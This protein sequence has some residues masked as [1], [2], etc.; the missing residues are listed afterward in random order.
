MA[1]ALLVLIWVVA[2]TMLTWQEFIQVAPAV[3]PLMLLVLWRR[4]SRAAL[5][6]KLASELVS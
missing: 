6:A 4:R 5:R 3:A 1:R 2:L